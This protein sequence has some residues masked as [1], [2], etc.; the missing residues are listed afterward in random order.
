METPFDLFRLNGVY[1]GTWK[2]KQGVEGLRVDWE[3][4]KLAHTGWEGQI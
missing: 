4:K 2:Q 3:G 1:L